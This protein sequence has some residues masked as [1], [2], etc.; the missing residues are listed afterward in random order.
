MPP[1][2]AAA[3]AAELDDNAD[4]AGLVQRLSVS[5]AG[6]RLLVVDDNEIN[7]IVVRAQLRLVG[8]EADEA[9]DG[10]RALE[11][12]NRADYDLILMDVQ[13]P[14]LDGL[15]ATRQIRTINRYRNIPIIALTADAFNADRQRV[16]D[17]GMSDHLAKPLRASQLYAA[18]AQWLA[19][20]RH[21]A[22]D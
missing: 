11:M 21:P 12:A 15:E 13:M 18:L 7:R 22:G 19:P 3:D 20:S 4:H 6:A 14:T 9:E 5:L 8:L 17:A 16:M 1:A 2:P 10:L